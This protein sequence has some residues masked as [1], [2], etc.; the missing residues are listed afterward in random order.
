V[1]RPLDAVIFDMDGTL[2]DSLDAVADGFIG[3]IVEAGGPRYTPQQIIDAFPRGWPAPMLTHLLGRPS[4]DAELANYHRVLR[5]RSAG[6]AA[7]PGVPEALDA[8][9]G[10]DLRLGLFTGAD[11]VSLDILLGVTG[12]RDRFEVVTGG[13]E[14]ARAKPAPDGILHTC[15]RLGVTPAKTAYVGDSPADMAAA[16]AAGAMAVGAGWGHLWPSDG[17]DEGR[18]AD[19]VAASP[20]E[21]IELVSSPRRPRR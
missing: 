3:T 17:R 12:L 20:L 19:M 4:T 6:I 7:Y 5:A 16:R 10:A 8:L 11:V 18:A 13:N 9:L 1:S 15:R 21:L 2:F 14:V